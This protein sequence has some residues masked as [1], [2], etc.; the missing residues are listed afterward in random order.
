MAFI[1]KYHLLVFALLFSTF[2]IRAQ[3]YDYTWLLGYESDGNLP[4]TEVVNLNFNEDPVSVT[5]ESRAAAFFVSSAMISDTSG[6]LLFYTDGCDIYNANDEI[7]EN[8]DDLNPGEVHDIQC[9]NENSNGYTAGWQSSIILPKPSNNNSYYIF[10]KKIEYIYEPDFEV[11]TTELL[12]SILDASTNGGL[13]EVTV[14][15]TPIIEEYLT[16]GE[17]VATKH[18]NGKDWWILTAGDDSNVYYSI[19]LTSEG[20]DTVFTD[21]HEYIFPEGGYTAFSPNGRYFARYNPAVGLLTFK[22]DR[23]TGKLSQEKLWVSNNDT[24]SGGV[25]FS[26]NSQL[27]YVSAHDTIYQYDMTA[28]DI[29]ASRQTVAVYDG[30]TEI[31]QTTF[32]T[33]QLAPDC[34]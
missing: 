30:N 7:V 11:V 1:P 16:F 13:G 18:A 8:G 10:H 21:A 20:I 31:F 19:L 15:N 27:L 9:N 3:K 12:Y 34:K 17:L 29:G 23:S 5:T 26:P 2:C 14:K 25:A 6:Q 28:L 24:F 22:F 33:A 32:H 4:G